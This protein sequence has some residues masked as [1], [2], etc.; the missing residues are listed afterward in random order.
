M[1]MTMPDNRWE[2]VRRRVYTTKDEDEWVSLEEFAFWL[3]N[4]RQTLGMSQK[5]LSDHLCYPEWVISRYE[6]GEQSPPDSYIFIQQVRILLKK[7]GRD[8]HVL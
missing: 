8:N 7:K 3:K 4:V 1:N 2:R 6:R 5:E